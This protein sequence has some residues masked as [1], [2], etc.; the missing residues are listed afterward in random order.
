MHKIELL[1]GEEIC[2]KCK[3][4]GN[5]ERDETDRSFYFICFRCR[6]TGKVDW[7][8]RAMGQRELSPYDSVQIPLVRHHYPK[9]IAKDLVG[10]QPMPSP[11]IV[12]GFKR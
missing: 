6:G 3:G 9:L 5:N 12:K 10:V 2:P 8:T 4:T 11:G 7:V 1:P